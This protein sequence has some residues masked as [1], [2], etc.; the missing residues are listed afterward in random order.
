MDSLT[1]I[2]IGACIGDLF[3]G[4]KIGRKAMLYGALAASLPDVDFIASFWLGPADN[5]FAHRGFTHSFLFAI[6][7]VL[8]LALIFGKRHFADRIPEST[9]LAFM[10]SEVFVHLFLDGFNAYGVGWFEPFSHYRVSYNTIFVADPFFSVWPGIAVVVLLVLNRN[11]SKRKTWAAWGLILCFSY[12]IYCF[13]NK[14]RIDQT[15][16]LEMSYQGIKYNR[17]LTTPTPFN[18][19]LWFIVAE[20]DS[21]FQ[22]GYRSVFDKTSRINFRYFPRNEYLL[23]PIYPQSDLLKLIRFS[24][25]YYTVDSSRNGIEFNDLRFGQIMG[26]QN[27]ASAFVFHY[28]LQKPDS[29][30]LVVQR[31]RFTDWNAQTVRYFL[32]RIRG[33]NNK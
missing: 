20:T 5:L 27:P 18:N 25:G 12:L 15:A 33:V 16:R 24:Q 23:R 14:F 29:N 2:A 10:G 32:R 3:L 13:S 8:M 7:S 31:G 4:K 9:W 17:Y 19:W 11:N 1:H 30:R 28:Y 22:L 26:W 6:L 21:G